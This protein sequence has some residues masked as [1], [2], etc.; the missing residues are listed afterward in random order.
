MVAALI[1]AI[2]SVFGVPLDSP[3]PWIAF[4]SALIAAAS[5]AAGLGAEREFR[6]CELIGP[7]LLGQL[8]WLPVVWS[9][10]MVGWAMGPLWAL[11]SLA[12]ALGGSS[13]AVLRL[14]HR[15]GEGMCA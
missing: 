2:G 4:A 15:R 10:L 3:I 5:V 8:Y 13:A 11:A 9:G 1:I 6:A 14:D 12:G 7:T